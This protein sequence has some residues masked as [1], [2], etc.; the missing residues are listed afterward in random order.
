MEAILKFNLPEDSED[1]TLALDGAKWSLAMWQINEWLRVN[2]KNPPEDM[3]DDTFNTLVLVNDKLH[4]I[5]QEERLK[6]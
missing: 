3:S 5:L 2:I 1:F 6:L 4:E